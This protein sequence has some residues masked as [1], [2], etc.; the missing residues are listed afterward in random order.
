MPV[1]RLSTLL[2]TLSSS[3]CTGVLLATLFLDER[4]L[5]P[6]ATGTGGKG[7]LYLYPKGFLSFLGRPLFLLGAEYM[8]TSGSRGL[9]Y[10]GALE[11]C[12]DHFDGRESKLSMSQSVD[13]MGELSLEL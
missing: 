13:G 11:G 3:L 12:T 7:W 5:V 6:W 2:G 9:E 1:S 8:G 4:L 10:W